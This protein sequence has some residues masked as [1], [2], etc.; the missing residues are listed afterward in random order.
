MSTARKLTFVEAADVETQCFEW[1]R[2]NWLSE[3]RVTGAERFSTG[4]VTVAP[5]QGH[6]R[7]NHPGSEE[8]LYIIKGTAQQMVEVDGEPVTR[9]VGPGMLVHIPAGAYHATVNTGAGELVVLAVYAPSGPEAIL[10][11]LPECTV[12]P[13][14]RQPVG[15]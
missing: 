10:R 9:E 8:I 1:G 4:V 2:L 11:A 5:G 15:P 13:P 3:P 14:R 6:V 7:H 12:E